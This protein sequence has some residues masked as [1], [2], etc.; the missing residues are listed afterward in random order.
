MDRANRNAPRLI[1]RILIGAL[2]LLA[3]LL[4][5]IQAARAAEIVPSVGIARAT[6]GDGE[7]KTFAGLARRTSLLPM[8]KS[9]IGI[10]Y[11][12]EPYNNGDLNVKMWP[13]TAS[14]WL[15]PLP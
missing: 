8:V 15:T 4:V 13:V 1:D 14:V 12:N 11:R 2:V 9:E 6:S 5:G 3:V 10:A 7:S